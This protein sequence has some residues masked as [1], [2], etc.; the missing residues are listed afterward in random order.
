M[1]QGQGGQSGS[2]RDA[3]PAR[4]QGRGRTFPA[5]RSLLQNRPGWPYQDEPHGPLIL[6]V[7]T[8]PTSTSSNI[9]FDALEAN[10]AKLRHNGVQGNRDR[11]GPRFVLWAI[12]ALISL[13]LR[14]GFPVHAIVNSDAD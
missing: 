13:W 4:R 5:A 3:N 14:T 11:G 7:R 12:L 8:Q 1:G 6:R 10:S 9:G 2:G